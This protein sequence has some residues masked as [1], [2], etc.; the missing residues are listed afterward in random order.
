MGKAQLEA[1]SATSATSVIADVALRFNFFETL[2]KLRCGV[3]SLKFVALQLRC[4][5]KFFSVNSAI[6]YVE[7]ILFHFYRNIDERCL[8]LQI[9]FS[10]FL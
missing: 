8:F 1:Q 2:R 10:F 4:A 5:L 3:K 9:I 6:L 7:L